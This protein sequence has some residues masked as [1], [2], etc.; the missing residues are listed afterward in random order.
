MLPELGGESQGS[1]ELVLGPVKPEVEGEGE[2]GE[3]R[4][5][6]EEEEA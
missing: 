4:G 3:Y 1:G 2:K 6:G 5:G